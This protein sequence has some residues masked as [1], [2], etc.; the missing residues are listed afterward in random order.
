M[1][2]VA[3]ELGLVV[4]GRPDG[5]EHGALAVDAQDG[6]PLVL[7]VFGLDQAS[8]LADA[9]RVADRVRARGVPVPDPYWVGITPECAYTLQR[10]ADG[11]VPGVLEESHA[12]QMLQF[13]RAHLDAVPEGGDWPE[14]AV[15]ALQVGDIEL[16]AVHEP[17]RAV[18]GEA[19]QLLEEIIEIGRSADPAVL[20]RTD[21]LHGD[22][23]HRNLLA[24]GS[25]VTAVIDWES[26]RAGDARYDLLLVNYW[27]DTYEG[28][29]VSPAASRQI[30]H[31]VDALVSPE[32]RPLL[33]A[34]VCLHQLWFVC[35]HRPERLRETVD[36][37]RRH[38][39]RHRSNGRPFG[40]QSGG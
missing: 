20:R 22:W 32:A 11:R 1:D 23:H 15:Q 7:K 40:P 27:T 25:V 6:E 31:A 16:W 19:L 28:A 30:R 5:G 29:G 12:L 18:G 9:L 26:A 35:A 8:R 37:V 21:A 24:N 14:R 34:L 39:G 3:A 13:W 2:R 36:R 33:A 17:I 38:L 4:V 10:R